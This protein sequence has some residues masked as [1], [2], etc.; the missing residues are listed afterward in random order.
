MIWW[1]RII[2]KFVGVLN[3]IKVLH[4][5]VSTVGGYISIVF[6]FLAGI[7]IGITSS[8]IRLKTFVATVI[9]KSYKSIMQEKKH[10]NI[11]LMKKLSYI[12]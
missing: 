5:L 12:P 6:D 7:P 8:T 10:N 3:Y 2:K 11:V 1:V 9:I 4:Y